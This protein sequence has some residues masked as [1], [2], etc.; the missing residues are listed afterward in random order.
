MVG[1][2]NDTRKSNL[3]KIVKK[4][5]SCNK[6]QTNNNKKQPSKGNLLF[7]GREKLR[8]E[9]QSRDVLGVFRCW[10]VSGDTPG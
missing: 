1:E 4:S 7:Q 3:Q 6:K 9:E 8:A 2:K 5:D 10:G